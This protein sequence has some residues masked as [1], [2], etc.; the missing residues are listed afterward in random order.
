MKIQNPKSKIQNQAGFTLIEMVLVLGIVALLVGA[1]IFQ[2]TG[3]LEGG[4]E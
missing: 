2:L 1:G 3:V 4:R